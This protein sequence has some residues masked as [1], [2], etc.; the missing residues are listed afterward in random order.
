M[1]PSFSIVINTLNRGAVLEKT[2]ESFRWLNYPGEFEVVVVNGPSTDNS[3]E[4]IASWLPKIRAGKCDLANLSVSRNVGI[5]MAQGDIVAFIDDDAI[6]EPEWL[7]QLAEAYRDPMVGAVGGFVYNHTGYD[8][9]YTYGVVD[10]FGHADLGMQEA[11]PH[12]SFPKS[13]RFPHLLGCNSSFRRSA[14]LEIG[15]FDEEFEYFLDETDVCLRIVDAGYLIAQLPRAY[16]HHKYAPSNIRGENKVVRNRYPVI[17]N[18]IYFS[19]KHARE[20]FPLERV[21][22]EISKFIESQRNEVIWAEG[23]GLLSHDDVTKFEDDVVRAMDTGMRRGFEGANPGAMISADKQQLHAGEFLPFETFNN[24]R[25]IVLTSRDFP[26]NHG[27]GIATFTK[28]LAEALATQG[29]MV[30][31]IT[32]SHD[33]N[34]VDFEN[35]VWVHRIVPRDI[36]RTPAAIE[37]NVPQ[38]I[39]NWSATALIEARRIAD[40]RDI[41]VVESPI[42]DCEGIAFLLEGKWPL[43]TSLHTTLHFF[44]E[45]HPEQSQNA[46]WMKSFGKPMLALEQEMMTRANAVR[47]NSRAIVREIEKI[48]GFRF[49]EGKLRVVPHG[50]ALPAASA[51]AGSDGSGIEV[52]FVGR[53]EPRKGIDV[54]LAAVPRI[55]EAN[56][57]VRF[58]IVGDDSMK[59]RGGQ[60]YKEKFLREHPQA[61]WL[62]RIRFDGRVSDKALHEAFAQCDVFVAPSRFESFGLVFLEAMRVGKPVIGCRAG[63]MPEVIENEVNGLLV[64]PGDVDGLAQAILRLARNLAER[65]GMGTRGKEAFIAKFTAG[66]M[67]RKSVELFELA[68][69]DMTVQTA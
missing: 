53:L 13:G 60:T 35:G 67:A 33:S 34:R 68:G 19:L 23:E 22:G 14:L 27:G 1:Y 47:A 25:A 69:A 11:T 45:S 5:C 24:G 59:L 29:S 3:G 43:V 32:Q 31:V 2:L 44:L 52:L 65:V 28:D 51:P 10:R 54:L 9:Q 38:H 62:D 16:V 39:W 7:T 56:P 30:H 15:G 17:K 12:L 42:W 49:N 64:E 55:L 58:R 18:K 48:Y 57:E 63:G 26:P 61:V 6:P 41:D 36:A 8:F 20:F 66:E 46:E 37:R 40:H 4:V 21:L 50:M